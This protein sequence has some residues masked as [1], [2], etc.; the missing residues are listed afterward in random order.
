MMNRIAP[1]APYHVLRPSRIN[2]TW[3]MDLTTIRIFS[4]LEIRV[5]AIL[6]G[7][8]RRVLKIK[9]FAGTPKAADA[10]AFV[11]EAIETYGR[12]RFLVVDNGS[13]FRKQFRKAIKALGIEPFS[14][15][16]KSMLLNGKIERWFRTM[17][18]WQR[19][20][21]LTNLPEKAA[22]QL[23]VFREWYNAERPMWVLGGRTPNEVWEAFRLAEAKAFR[24][25]APHRPI[26]KVER[27]AYLDDP[28]LPVISIELTGTVKKTA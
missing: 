20:S 7:F 9:V 6:D 16:Y 28:Y 3:H 25:R 17:K 22:A 8:S 11:K 1:V 19:L 14:R 5:M 23:E 21:M 4:I 18:L 15:K 10:I 2:G 13:Q 27:E 26:F 12:P 24:A